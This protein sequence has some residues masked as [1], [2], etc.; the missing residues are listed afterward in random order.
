MRKSQ[1]LYLDIQVMLNL[2][3]IYL[4]IPLPLSHLHKFYSIQFDPFSYVNILSLLDAFN[5][6]MGKLL[7]CMLVDH[8]FSILQKTLLFK[9]SFIL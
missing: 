8:I 4:S 1:N 5:Q 3:S 7:H 9:V 2:V 6:A